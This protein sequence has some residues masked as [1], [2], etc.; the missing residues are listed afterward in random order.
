MEVELLYH[1]QW[2]LCI[3][4]LPKREVGVT[5][6]KVVFRQKE[7]HV[8]I[9]SLLKSLFFYMQEALHREEISGVFLKNLKIGFNA[10]WKK[11]KKQNITLAS[12]KCSTYM[13]VPALFFGLWWCGY[14]FQWA[15]IILINLYMQAAQPN[16]SNPSPSLNLNWTIQ[17]KWALS[18]FFF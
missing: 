16:A 8:F 6:D 15:C 12:I 9:H 2:K 4:L 13:L 11:Q 5:Q 7:P 18:Q 3:I 1:R 10:L 14:P 17:Q